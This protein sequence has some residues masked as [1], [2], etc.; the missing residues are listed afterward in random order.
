MQWVFFALAM[1]NFCV[2]Q[3]Q[4]TYRVS[5]QDWDY[6][7][8]FSARPC[9]VLVSVGTL[10]H[11]PKTKWDIITFLEFF[12]STASISLI[13]S[14][15]VL[16]ATASSHSGGCLYCWLGYYIL[17]EFSLLTAHSDCVPRK[18]AKAILNLTWH[19]FSLK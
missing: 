18:K 9:R 10:S 13:L 12:L 15:Q 11:C 3:T 5:L 1:W 4:V 6:Q 14:L 8:L 7:H 19:I 16:S 2:S 17:L